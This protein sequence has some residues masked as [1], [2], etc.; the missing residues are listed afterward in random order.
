MAQPIELSLS[1]A[2]CASLASYLNGAPN[3]PGG[4]NGT[5]VENANYTSQNQLKQLRLWLAYLETLD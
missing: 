1:P 4:F 5:D 2:E 3:S